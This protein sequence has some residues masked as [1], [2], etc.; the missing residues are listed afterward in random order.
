[1]AECYSHASQFADLP[2]CCM[3]L[4]TQLTQAIEEQRQVDSNDLDDWQLK[5]IPRTVALQQ[6]GYQLL[7]GRV[8]RYTSS[9]GAKRGR[10]ALADDLQWG[11]AQS[12]VSAPGT[13]QASCTHPE[14]GNSMCA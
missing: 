2:H 12:V 10:Y 3:Q 9:H 5:I 8:G 11:L 7:A 6:A 1:M 14:P 13:W 4:A